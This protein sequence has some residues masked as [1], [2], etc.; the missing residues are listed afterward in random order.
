MTKQEEMLYSA[1][2]SIDEICYS[3]EP[4]IKKYD[5]F[6]FMEALNIVDDGMF[7]FSDAY[8]ALENDLN[9]SYLGINKDDGLPFLCRVRKANGEICRK[10]IGRYIPNS[11]SYVMAYSDEGFRDHRYIKGKTI[12]ILQ[13]TKE[14]FKTQLPSGYAF[15]GDSERELPEMAKVVAGL[16][17]MKE[18]GFS[19]YIKPQGATTGFTMP[20]WN[21][22]QL[23]D[24][25]KMREIEDG[26]KRRAALRHWVVGHKRLKPKTEDYIDIERHLRGRLDCSWQGMQ[27]IVRQP[28]SAIKT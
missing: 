23:K 20:I 12:G 26:M 21:L 15:R 27:V 4:T 3:R 28:L 6:V 9:I 1:A 22:S 25:F 13:Y 11:A 14:G 19:V 18:N 16:Q 7:F 8:E 17:F 5:G 10:A 24:L 2:K